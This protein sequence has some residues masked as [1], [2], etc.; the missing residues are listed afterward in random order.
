MQDTL[1]SERKV[2][3][4]VKDRDATIAIFP[5]CMDRPGE[6]EALCD[7]LKIVPSHVAWGN[8]AHGYCKHRVDILGP[9]TPHKLQQAQD[10]YITVGSPTD[11][12]IEAKYPTLFQRVKMSVF[13]SY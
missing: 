10:S 13:G 11:I 1:K 4:R 2:T 12:F 9:V 3:A 5:V 7:R 6:L 8:G